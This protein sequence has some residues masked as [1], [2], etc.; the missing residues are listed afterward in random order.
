MKL[1]PLYTLIGA[2]WGLLF[3]ILVG[4][5][6]TAWAAGIG[7]LY[8]FGD[9]RWPANAGMIMISAGVVAGLATLLACLWVGWR[10]GVK[11]SHA[12]PAEMA[13]ARRR[14]MW[15][16]GLWLATAGGLVLALY[17]GD[18]ARKGDR[19]VA[20]LRVAGFAQ[21]VTANHHIARA[22]FSGWR[23]ES[24]RARLTLAGNRTGA[25]ELAWS[26]SDQAY[27]EILDRGTMELSLTPGSHG[28]EIELH[29]D[30]LREAYRTQVL[31]GGGGVLVEE[32]FMLS[33]QLTPLLGP[34]VSQGIPA[35]ELQNLS[36]GVSPLITTHAVEIPVRFRL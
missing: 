18:A 19:Q 14:G 25:Y 6:V 3:G 26:V 28:V 27:G 16:L 36:L 24:G 23:Q 17:L 20:E 13:R 2:A 4:A 12:A 30:R 11:F 9:D 31:H 21:L 32:A 33:V 22:G 5:V 34:T 7:W 15:L 35:N 10:R 8:M 29:L 1:Q